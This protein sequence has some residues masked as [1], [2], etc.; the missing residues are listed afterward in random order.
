MN[1]RRGIAALCL[2]GGLSAAGL[3]TGTP[4]NAASGSYTMVNYGSGMCATVYG[5]VYGNGTPVRHCTGANYA[6]NWE[7]RAA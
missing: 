2:V 5:D 6:Q 4:A 7:F 3:A 1:I